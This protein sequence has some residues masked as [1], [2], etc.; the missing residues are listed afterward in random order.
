[1]MTTGFFLAWSVCVGIPSKDTGGYIVNWFS[2]NDC[3][4]S[5]LLTWMMTAIHNDI[6]RGPN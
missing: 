6:D 5:L 2:G 1:M 4:L 3:E